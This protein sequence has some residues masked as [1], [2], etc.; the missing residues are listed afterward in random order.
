MSYTYAFIVSDT[1]INLLE[2]NLPPYIGI[3]DTHPMYGGRC[4]VLYN[5]GAAIADGVA[6]VLAVY[7]DARATTSKQ[8][9]AEWLKQRHVTPHKGGRT[10]KRS[11]DVTPETNERLRLL[12]EQGISLG[13]LIEESAAAKFAQLAA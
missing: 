13:D 4:T 5:G 12:A 3:G 7:P 1:P 11:T 8:E 9:A 6:A 10:I 2:V